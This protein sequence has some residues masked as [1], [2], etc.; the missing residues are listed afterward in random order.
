[1][2]RAE[3]TKTWATWIL[4]EDHSGSE[5]TREARLPVQK[6]PQAPRK[7]N[8]CALNP[9]KVEQNLHPSPLPSYDTCCHV[10]VRRR[11]YRHI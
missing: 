11:Y 3:E 9:G 7:G 4:A 1:M 2:M 10:Q 5:N 8:G 6:A